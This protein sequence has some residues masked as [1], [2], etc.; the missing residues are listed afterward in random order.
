MSGR[1]TQTEPFLLSPEASSPEARGSLRLL[2]PG[3]LP[4]TSYSAVKGVCTENLFRTP[5]HSPLNPRQS[6]GRE[7]MARLNPSTID[8]RGPALQR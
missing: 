1:R 6:P 8:Q 3:K 2:K 4:S 5:T 7:G